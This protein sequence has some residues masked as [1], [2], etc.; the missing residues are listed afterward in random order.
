M[1]AFEKGFQRGIPLEKAASF[2][3]GLK[4]GGR[5]LPPEDDALL[6]EA[7]KTAAVQSVEKTAAQRFDELVLQI[8]LAGE[9]GMPASSDALTSPTPGKTDPDAYLANEQEAQGEEDQ[10]SV[11][12]Y[13]QRLEEMRAQTAQADQQVQE[14]QQQ[15]EQLTAQQQEHDTQV[16]AATQEGQ[17]AQQAAMQQ[18]NAANTMASQAMQSAVDASNKAL[19]AKAT[20]TTAKI[21][22]QGLR[23]QLFDLASEGLPG[24]EPDV[25][26]AGDAAE[27]LA[28]TGD[29]AVPQGAAAA[30]GGEAAPAAGGQESEA[31]GDAG[32]DSGGLNEA[33]APAGAEGMPGAEG[34][35]P[36]AAAAT[37]DAVPPG[38]G[39]PD[40]PPQ[41]PAGGAAPGPDAAT[42]PAGN[43][44][45]KVGFDLGLAIDAHRA[46][47]AP[48]AEQK[49]KCAS[50]L[51]EYLR[52][53]EIIGALAGGIGGAGLA[54]AEASG[55]G[56]DMGKLEQRI[57]EGE[58]TAKKPGLK[59]FAQA[60]DL[61]KDKAMHTLGQATQNHPVAATITGGLLGAGA[62]YA[63]GPQL[64]ALGSEAI[65]HHK[66]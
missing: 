66:G 65:A 47:R 53:P 49:T 54:G 50:A 5:P 33:G 45:I 51:P 25:G 42:K 27:G 14:L 52:R 20:E 12:Y 21:Q 36:D 57:S 32:A 2:F 11:A 9:D 44:H 29:V 17:I 24:T 10:Q 37:P 22:Q 15:V 59:G 38:G 23:T 18:V 16:S 3:I 60:F 46:R 7:V 1:N 13:Q 8:K 41:A 43:V 61:A 19:E 26:G 34:G 30:P 64:K 39:G 6:A 55:H 4:S 62:G 63:A 35:A 28:P 48:T 40:A 31:G 56:P 58:E